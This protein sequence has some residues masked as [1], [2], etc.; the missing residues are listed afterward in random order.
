MAHH[1]DRAP[2]FSHPSDDELFEVAYGLASDAERSWIL[3]HVRRCPGC[4]ERFL[5]VNRVR[6]RTRAEVYT[7]VLATETMSNPAQLGLTIR[8]GGA[9]VTSEGVEGRDERSVEF[10]GVTTIGAGATFRRLRSPLAIAASVTLCLFAGD[11]ILESAHQAS[12]PISLDGEWVVLRSQRP[13]ESPETRST[14]ELA[15]QAYESG[16]LRLA[17]ERLETMPPA[18]VRYGFEDTMQS[19]IRAAIY[20][21]DGRYRE[22]ITVLDSIRLETVP[23][24]WESRG[25]LILSFAHSG[26]G[27]EVERRKILDTL[28]TGATPEAAMARRLLGE[29]GDAT[30]QRYPRK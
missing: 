6:E 24:P 20:V 3:S 29:V 14:L 2:E 27:N 16:D 28:A 9:D 4:E 19:L 21:D 22:A 26:L 25:L 15:I 10:R 7:G 30:D 18:E 23:E 17:K 13:R 5:F 11:A 12:R 8:G 1:H